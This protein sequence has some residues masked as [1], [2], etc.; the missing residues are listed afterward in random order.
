MEAE[1]TAM[2]EGEEIP[3]LTLVL[4]R[5]TGFWAEAKPVQPSSINIVGTTY[6]RLGTGRR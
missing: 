1:V 6:V 5:N 2:V 4:A 3:G